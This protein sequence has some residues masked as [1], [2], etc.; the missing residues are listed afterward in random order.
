MGIVGRVVVVDVGERKL[1]REG[2]GGRGE[3]VLEQ[4]RAKGE[5]NEFA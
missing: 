5:S 4:D 2:G 1:R 3:D